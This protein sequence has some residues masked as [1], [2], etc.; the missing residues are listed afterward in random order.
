MTNATIQTVS[1]Q[2]RFAS[3]EDWIYTDIKGWTLADTID[4]AGYEQ[5]RQVAP[6]R[7]SQ[8]VQ[9]DGSV[10]FDAPAHIVTAVWD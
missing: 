8:F 6:P 9:A 7:L 5:L 2:V 10:S 1:G 4:E 3:I